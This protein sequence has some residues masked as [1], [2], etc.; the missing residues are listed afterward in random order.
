MDQLLRANADGFW[1]LLNTA[2]LLASSWTRI[3]FF[4]GSNVADVLAITSEITANWLKATLCNALV[5][6]V[7]GLKTLDIVSPA[8]TVSLTRSLMLDQ[9]DS[10]ISDRTLLTLS[11]RMTLLWTLA[12]QLTYCRQLT[13]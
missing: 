9:A 10:R 6:P 2:P 5:S 11:G 7:G 13:L 1:I 3:L 8:E 12:A 4:V